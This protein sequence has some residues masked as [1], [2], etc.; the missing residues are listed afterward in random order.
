MGNR[1]T[2]KCRLSY[3]PVLLINGTSYKLSIVLIL[4]W[5]TENLLWVVIYRCTVTCCIILQYC[6]VFHNMF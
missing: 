6:T 2:F 4:F 5:M 3:N 1:W